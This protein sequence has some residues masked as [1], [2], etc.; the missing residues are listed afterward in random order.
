MMELIKH[1]VPD[2]KTR[3]HSTSLLLRQ[4]KELRHSF[5]GLMKSSTSSETTLKNTSGSSLELSVSVLTVS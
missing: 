3:G 5:R 1:E 4:G 2:R